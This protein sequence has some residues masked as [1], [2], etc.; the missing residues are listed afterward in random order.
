VKEG[1]QDRGDFLDREVYPALFARLDSAFPEF[2]WKRRGATAWEA[3]VWPAGFPYPVEHKTPDRLMVYA[4]R[5]WWIK[6]H[7]HTGVRFLDYV[8]GGTRPVG[9]AFPDAVRKLAK[10][11]GVPFPERELSEEEREKVHKREGRRAALEAVIA[12]AQEV[13]F[14]VAGAEARDYLHGRGFTD[15]DMGTLRL[16][17]YL[18]D[19]DVRSALKK[20]G[21]ANEEAEAAAL[22]WKKLEGYILVP[23][24]DERGY[25]L[26]LYGRWV[27]TPPEGKPKTIALPGEGTKASPLYFDRAR[28]AGLKELVLVEGVFDAALLQARGDARVVASVAAQLSGLQVET[29]VR[30]RIRTVFVCGDPDGGGDAGNIANVDA[31]TRVGI[32]SFVVRRLPNSM[33]PDQYVLEHGLSAWKDL[34]SDSAPGVV[35]KAA[36]LLENVSP[37]SPPHE[38]R[39]AVDRFSAYAATLPKEVSAMDQEDL[40]RLVSERTGFYCQTLLEE[41]ERADERREV[42]ERR[43][44]LGETLRE[45]LA[46]VSEGKDPREVSRSLEVDLGSTKGRLV[47]TQPVVSVADELDSL[48]AHLEKWRGVDFLGLPQRVLPTLDTYTSGL[49]GLMLLAARPGVG[50]TVLG[51]QFGVDVVRHNRDAS[52]LFVS[53]EMSRRDI[54]TRILSRLSGLP[55]R[56]LVF[57]D[58]LLT[59]ESV[60]ERFTKDQEQLIKKAERELEDFG[61]RI[62]ILDSRNF[63]EPT[64]E[65]VLSHLNALKEKTRTSRA[66]VLLD[67]LQVWPIARGDEKKVRSD[68]DADKYRIGAMKE[69]RDRSQEDAVFV[70]SEARKPVGGGSTEWGGDLEDVMGSARGTYTPDMVFLFRPFTDAERKKENLQED[71]MTREKRKGHKRAFNK[72]SIPKGRDGVRRATLD[73]TFFYELSAFTE[74]LDTTGEEP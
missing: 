8:N 41:L 66:F 60:S 45:A 68:L 44:A 32:Q 3:T 72:L 7:G 50:K 5:P 71:D 36:A 48:R 74:G 59:K 15:E 64:V 39:I 69:L 22:P 54:M 25:P 14:S 63:P 70:I 6:V 34:V 33:D 51:V 17:C 49:R 27:G 12:H 28:A 23:W 20:A 37:T 11:A 16:G 1:T 24:M 55:W 13:L 21:V 52:F 10:L 35:F 61:R 18:S 67:Y 9:P 46:A 73:L 4:D 2:E 43:K 38:K 42:E 65:G 40:L 62:R 56:T 29:L 58:E 31:L 53:M 19:K 57:G 26:T 47:D 30:N